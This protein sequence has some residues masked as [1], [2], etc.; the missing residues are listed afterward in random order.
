MKKTLAL[1]SLV[2]TATLLTGCA[3]SGSYD[4]DESKVIPTFQ[5]TLDDGRKMTC[6]FIEKVMGDA[7]TGGPSCD[8]D[9]AK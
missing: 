3:S 4:Y 2:F 5:V 7:S 8:W 1:V 6:I 9:G